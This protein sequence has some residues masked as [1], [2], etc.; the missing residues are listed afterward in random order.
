[1]GLQEKEEHM[2]NKKL[3][4]CALMGL[5]LLMVVPAMAVAP[6][7]SCSNDHPTGT[8]PVG[9]SC[10]ITGTHWS[11]WSSGGCPGGESATCEEQCVFS[12]HY[13]HTCDGVHYRDTQHRHLITDYGCVVD[14]CPGDFT[15]Q[16]GDYP[17]QG[18]C[19]S[20]CQSG[21]G[22]N[23]EL[24]CKACG[25]CTDATQCGDQNIC[26]V[27]S[28]GAD[29]ACIHTPLVCD[30]QNACTVNSCDAIQGCVFT[31]LE[32]CK[33]CTDA[34]GCADGNICTDNPCVEGVCQTVNH[35][36]LINCDG[37]ICTTG[38]ICSGGSCTEGT[39]AVCENEGQTCNPQSGLC[40]GA[41]CG[42]QT[43]DASESC[44]TCSVDCGECQPTD[45]CSGVQ[46]E[47]GFHCE[48]RGEVGVCIQD[49]QLGCPD[50]P[51]PEGQICVEGQCVSPPVAPAGEACYTDKIFG[52]LKPLDCG[53]LGDAPAIDLNSVDGEPLYVTVQHWGG[54]FSCELA[55]HQGESEYSYTDACEAVD[56]YHNGCD[57]QRLCV[58]T[59]ASITTTGSRDFRIKCA[60]N[61]VNDNQPFTVQVI[62]HFVD[63][64]GVS[65]GRVL[66]L[67]FMRE[68][69]RQ[70][71]R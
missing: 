60:P 41:Y 8:C 32:G 30:D 18:N 10:E 9:Q 47:E 68:P 34:K 65:D 23:C 38:D 19:V 53:G 11:S 67:R 17:N 42:D 66:D 7:Y 28:C 39:P 55:E 24:T 29:G 61:N 2:E 49:P 37:N 58:G 48:A 69:D 14:T 3:Y 50:N 36:G 63:Y 57:V 52:A 43:C 16:L 46:C 33:T 40:E 21:G 1:M 71:C 26:T 64:S 56:Y 6:V 20:T 13:S 25:E 54:S 51:C 15:C 59:V 62:D 4:I 45:P 31:P 12:D 27:D 44:V 5:M 35:D 22:Q 70:G